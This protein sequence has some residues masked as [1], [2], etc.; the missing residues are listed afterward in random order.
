MLVLL[1]LMRSPSLTG[2][3]L[4][5]P[6]KGGLTAF[7]SEREPVILL[8]HVANTLELNQQHQNQN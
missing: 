2:G 8:I 1:R 7:L 4:I 6:L 5:G 3:M